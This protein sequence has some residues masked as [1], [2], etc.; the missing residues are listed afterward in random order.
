MPQERLDIWNSPTAPPQ[1]LPQSVLHGRCGALL[2]ITHG[3]DLEE[4]GQARIK[5]CINCG[6]STDASQPH[7]KVNNSVDPHLELA[8]K[9]VE[10]F[11]VNQKKKINS[12]DIKQFGITSPL[13]GRL[14]L[15]GGYGMFE[16]W[17]HNVPMRCN[18]V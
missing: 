18:E 14:L 9:Q 17:D 13:S 6:F 15:C 3:P 7:E 11:E 1:L 8:R 16:L 2:Q 5:R 12:A 10:S 4:L